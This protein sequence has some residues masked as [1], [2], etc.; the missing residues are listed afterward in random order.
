MNPVFIE[1]QKPVRKKCWSI[2]ALT[3]LAVFLSFPLQAQFSTNIIWSDEFNYSGSPDSGKWDFDI[4]GGGWGNNELQHYTSRTNNARVHNGALVINARQENYGGNAYTSARLASRNR[5]DWTYGR[6]V[7]R[8]RFTGANGTWPAIWM[9]PTDWS[10][11]GWPDSGE[12][13]LMEHVSTHGESVQASIHT[14][15]YNFQINTAKV[16]FQYGVDYWNWHEYILEWYPNRLDVA[17]DGSRYF[18]FHNEGQGFGKWPFDKRFHLM[19]NIAV[20]GWGGS[21]S[22]TSETM[23][24]D[25]VRAYGYTGQPQVS[26]H[27]QAW[28]RLVNRLS[29]KVL[30]VSGPSTADAANVHQWDWFDLHN[31]QWRFEAVGDG[32]YRLIARHSG[33]ACDVA[34]ASWAD[35]ANVQ[36]L[37]VNG[38]AAQ[39]WWLQPVGDGYC[40]IVN[41]ESG[42]V[43]DVANLSLTNGANVQQWAYVGGLN[44]Q[45]RIEQVVAPP[46]PP[47]PTGLQAVAGGERGTLFWN[48]GTNTT[49]YNL[50]R[51][52]ISGGAYTV[53]A[54]NLSQ[55]SFYDTGLMSCANYY[56]VVSAMNG[57]SESGNSTEVGVV[58][59]TVVRARNSGG[60]AQPPF[61][62]DANVVGGATAASSAV[63]DT[64]GLTNPA[65]QA[66][67]QTERYGNFTYTFT[68]LISGATYKVRLHSAETFWT[69]VGQRRFNV[70]INGAQ[71]LTNFDIIAAAGAQNKAVINEFNA[72]ATGGQITIQYVTVTDNARASGIEIILPQPAA[73]TAT[74]NGPIWAGMTLNLTASTVPGAT[75]NWTGP[76]GFNSTNQNPSIANA[77]PINSGIFSVTASAGGCTSVATTTSVIVNPPASL[78]I[79]ALAGSVI[80][81]WPGGTLQSTTNLS[82]PWSN[83]SGAISPRTNPVSNSQEFFRVK[84]Q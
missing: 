35:G 53:I 76:N 24:V 19:L 77:T 38:A 79:Q 21:P 42:R 15:D 1:E 39:E 81:S 16:G 7:V 82:D 41:R 71:V 57:T 48:A 3:A 47:V 11:G 46:A 44:Q 75:Y 23:E 51:A 13:D 9:L 10:Y 73:P 80:L 64:A 72:V 56:Y 50:K 18:S 31:Q 70:I 36:Q 28:Y 67:Y 27:P 37:S 49:S 69:A 59:W 17:I 60:A 5:G 45:W 65:P 43:L 66:V 2:A 55:P 34:W 20:G 32:A 14:R 4:G 74:N 58:P 6:V 68:G 78:A 8:A 30:D 63:I 54:T 40:K 61:A 83:V 84:L 52:N 26:V 22:F 12:I 25:F 62:A 29:G 33:K